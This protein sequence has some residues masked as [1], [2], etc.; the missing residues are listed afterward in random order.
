MAIV[1]AK[2][3]GRA[4]QPRRATGE[5]ISG[6]DCNMHPE[7]SD[8]LVADVVTGW[9]MSGERRFNASPDAVNAHLAAR[10]PSLRQCDPRKGKGSGQGSDTTLFDAVAFDAEGRPFGVNVKMAAS[11]KTGGTAGACVGSTIREPAWMGTLPAELAAYRA[12]GGREVFVAIRA[13]RDAEGAYLL[14]SSEVEWHISHP[15]AAFETGLP[16]AVARAGGRGRPAKGAVLPDTWASKKRSTCAEG[17]SWQLCF[18]HARTDTSDGWS[19]GTV[20]ELRAAILAA[21]SGPR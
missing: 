9:V 19:R 3:D 4:L 17:Y 21:G 2:A 6:D 8:R 5:F 11:D 7:H 13:A 14:S 15:L 18:R 1:L 20:A 10:F 12:A 16:D